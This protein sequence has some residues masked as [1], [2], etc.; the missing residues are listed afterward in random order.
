M[1]GNPLV[2]IWKIKDLRERIFFTLMILVVFRLGTIIPI[3]GV[4]FNTLA[5]LVAEE[6]VERSNI[7]SNTSTSSPEGLLRITASSS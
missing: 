5:S 6:E 2:D 1:A 4:E 7:F 3:P